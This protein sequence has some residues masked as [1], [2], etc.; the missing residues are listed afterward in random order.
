MRRRRRHSSKGRRRRRRREV[1]R[2]AEATVGKVRGGDPRLRP[3][4]RA[5]WLGTFVTA[6]EAARAYDRAAVAMR[7]RSRCSTS[8]MRPRRRPC[9]RSQRRGGEEEWRDEQQHGM[10]ELNWS[11]WMINCWMS[12]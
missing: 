9:G 5:V 11:A 10:R 7:G 3:E 8:P 12:C 6:E 4:R 2:G 1:P